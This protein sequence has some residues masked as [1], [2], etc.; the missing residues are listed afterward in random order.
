MLSFKQYVLEAT[1]QGGK[2]TEY[3]TE[4]YIT[5]YIG[6]RD[7]HTLHAAH[8]DIP[9]GASVSVHGHHLGHNSGTP[10]AIV[11]YQGKRYHVPY[12]KINKPATGRSGK[13]TYNDEHAHVR[14]WNHMVHKGIAHDAEAMHKELAVAKTDTSHPLHF[15][16]AGNAGFSGGKRT[17]AHKESYH[18]ELETAVHSVHAMA[19]HK[20]F[21]KAVKDR[22]HA[23]VS[24]AGRGTVSSTWQKHGAKEGTSKADV[25]IT[26]PKKK[27]ER[28]TL[29]MKKG[30]GSQLMS[31]G[32]EE[33]KAVH[34]HA[35]TH[36][37]SH[38][39]DYKHLSKEK[40]DEIHHSVMSA[41]DTVSH[42]LNAMK[43]ASREEQQHHKK[44]AQA[45]LDD[46]HTKHPAL[47]SYV[48][49]EA[50]TGHGKFGSAESEHAANYLVKSAAGGQ[51]ASV[52]HVDAV[53]YNG[54]KPRVAL[55]KEHGRTGNVKA[56]EKKKK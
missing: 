27:T 37:L 1:L 8:E 15:D 4:K 26:N 3:D 45:A 31:A 42:H 5:P 52:T 19:Q 6:Q 24:G 23:S 34:D 25:V 10:H 12:R 32:P 29:S 36:M 51:S 44:Q 50:T 48:R 39:D 28:L 41:I 54:P 43:G 17:E 53:D 16:N 35:V 49:R 2:R 18:K 40:K 22:W 38:H 33:T 56:D 14:V 11:S 13:K 20:D 47:N 46:I 55:P 21:H 30:E 9:A 7:T